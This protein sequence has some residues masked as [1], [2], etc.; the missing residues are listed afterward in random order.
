MLY[1]SWHK[2]L[3][4]IRKPADAQIIKPFEQVFTV[5]FMVDNTFLSNIMCNLTSFIV[6]TKVSHKQIIH[7]KIMEHKQDVSFIY[8]F[9]G[10]HTTLKLEY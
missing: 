3:C 2:V 6:F 9:F 1:F 4:Y 8:R 7:L 5:I 10:V